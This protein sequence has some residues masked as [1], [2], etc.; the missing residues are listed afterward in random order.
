MIKT[1][2]TV[3]IDGATIDVTGHGLYLAGTATANISNTNI[4]AGSTAI[5]IRAGKLNIKDGTYTS[6]GEFKTSPN[7]MVQ[8]LMVLL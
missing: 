1:D 6:A 2:N 5:E 3:N 8:R 7:E 4:Y